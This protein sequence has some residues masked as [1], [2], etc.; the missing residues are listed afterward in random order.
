M[1]FNKSVECLEKSEMHRLLG[2]ND[3]MM[4]IRGVNVFPSQIENI[5][6]QIEATEPH[7]QI[8]INRGKYHI[9]EV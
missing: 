1:I 7:Y 9:D 5:L 4:I 8:I 6:M 2:R 3:D